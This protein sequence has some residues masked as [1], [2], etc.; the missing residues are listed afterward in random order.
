[1][2]EDDPKE[3]NIEYVLDEELEEDEPNVLGDNVVPDDDVDEDMLEHD[4]DDD[5]DMANPFNT[6]SEPEDTYVELDKELED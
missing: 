1:M 6:F 3:H 5:V 4:I 2:E